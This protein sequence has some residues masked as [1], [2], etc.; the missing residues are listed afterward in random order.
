MG[1]VGHL[2]LSLFVASLITAAPTLPPPAEVLQELRRIE[3]ASLK[4][5]GDDL[6]LKYQDLARSRPSDVQLRIYLAWVVLPSDDSW[7]QLKAIAAINPDNP[8]VHLGMGRTYTAWKMR[9]QAK[10]EYQTI[11]AKDPKFSAAIVGMAELML[12][13][14]DLKGA[15]AQF[16][17]S[18]ALYDD[19]RAHAGLGLT[20]LE[21]GKAADARVELDK[22]IKGWGE[23]PAV[24][25]ALLKIHLEAKDAPATTDTAARLAELDPKDPEVRRIL[26]DLRF[27]EGN[28]A[29]AAKEYERWLRVAAP[30][31]DVLARLE[32]LYADLKDAEGEERTLQLHASFEKTNPAPSVRLAALAEAK[33]NTRSPKATCSRRSIATRRPRVPTCSWRGCA[34]NA[35][36]CSTRSTSTALRASWRARRARRR[37]RNGGTWRRRSS[38]PPRLP[39]ARSIR[40][41][42]RSP[43]AS[44]PF[45]SSERKRSRR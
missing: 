1:K 2:M 29:E 45:I 35:T 3:S 25:R 4:G 40:S 16:K 27:D 7:N 38:S 17:A 34:A 9:D 42:P 6:R 41:T 21:A 36:R 31:A 33:G 23:Q 15:E 8:W 24:L 19:P 44:T 30:T 14:G 20:L 43:R 5:K 37:S 11:L 28:K 39:R 10:A 26:A 13:G 22:A 18:L 32:T 12:L